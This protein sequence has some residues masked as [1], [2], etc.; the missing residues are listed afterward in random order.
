MLS[1]CIPVYNCDVTELVRKLLAQIKKNTVQAEIVLI[2]DASAVEFQKI[3]KLLAKLD[4]IRYV[5]LAENIGRAKIRNLFLS[6]THFNYLLFLDCDSQIS[7]DRFIENYLR[8]IEK[9]QKIVCGGRT[10][11]VEIPANT[12]Y[13]RWKYGLEREC[14][15]ANKRGEKPY[16]SFMTN[17]FL[18]H[19]SVLNQISFDERIAQYGH[20]DTL[21]GYRLKQNKIP[22]THIN[23]PVL[24]IYTE[25][26]LEF[27]EKTVLGLKNL[28][29]I[30]KFVN[31]KDFDHEIKLL[32]VFR[33]TSRYGLGSVFSFLYIC[34]GNLIFRLL[35]NNIGGIYLF[36][37]YK[38]LFLSKQITQQNKAA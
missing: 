15:L 26:N 7:D 25:S 21:F 9:K 27:L 24:H 35:K 31:N 30:R 36:D 3:N 29:E 4:C 10:Y 34:L 14:S 12:H 6:Y 1:V 11:P 20:E 18:I 22:L 32:R 8:Q 37:L 19:V 38:L 5:Q 23:N 33:K 16:Q 28:V 17:N 13:L 2:D